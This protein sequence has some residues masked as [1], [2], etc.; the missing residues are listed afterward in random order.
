M[1]VAQWIVNLMMVYA[2]VG[3]LFAVVFVI[4]GV[5]KLDPAARHSTAGFRFLIL[6]GAAALWPLLLKRWLSNSSYPPIEKNDHRNRARR[7]AL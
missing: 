6:F 1:V 3:F 5:G 7:N 4:W 2:T